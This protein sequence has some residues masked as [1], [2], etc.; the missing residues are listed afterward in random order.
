MAVSPEW[1]GKSLAEA[2]LQAVETELRS[3]QGKRITL[4]TTELPGERYGSMKN[5]ALRHPVEH[6]ICTMIL[7]QQYADVS[8]KGG[9]G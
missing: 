5:T 8:S 2:L 1:Q 3:K 7:Q 9:K 6:Q 4:D